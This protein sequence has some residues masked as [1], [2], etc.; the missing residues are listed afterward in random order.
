MARLLKCD[1][2]GAP[3]TVHLVRICD[4]TTSRINFCAACARAKGVVDEAGSPT[5]MLL[6]SDLFQDRRDPEAV[7]HSTCAG[8]GLT[9]TELLKRKTFGCERCYETFSSLLDSLLRRIQRG[10]EHRGKKPQSRTIFLRTAAVEWD[11]S[12]AR[13]GEDLQKR[14]SRDPRELELLL[15]LA[16]TEE[17][18]EEAALIRHHIDMLRDTRKVK[19]HKKPTAKAKR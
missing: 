15:S 8:C 6:G 3:A 13:V 1:C 5:E 2:C 16:V 12:S 14:L 17:R 9:G 4:G 11:R 7:V 19:K 10:K 18:Y